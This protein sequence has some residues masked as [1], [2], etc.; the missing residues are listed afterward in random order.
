MVEPNPSV[1]LQGV[2]QLNQLGHSGLVELQGLTIRQH[3]RGVRHVMARQPRQRGSHP[4]VTN[5]RPDCSP[6]GSG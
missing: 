6:A 2:S 5:V 1:E 4:T 3:V